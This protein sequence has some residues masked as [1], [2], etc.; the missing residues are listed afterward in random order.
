MSE[1]STNDNC[2]LCEVS[3]KIQFGNLRTPSHSSSENLFKPSKR[4][5][6]FGVVLS[7]IC[8]QVGLPLT[9]DSAKYSD[10]VCNP[11]GRKIR[12]LG[13]L[14]QFVKKAATA[15]TSTPVKTSKRTLDTPEKA[16]PPWRKSKS[17]RI[18][19]PVG[20][21]HF[22]DVSPAKSRKSL[23][24]AGEN[25]ENTSSLSLERENEMLSK[26]NVENLPSDGV[27][28]LYLNQSGNVT[29]RIPRDSQTKT[30][31][32]NIAAKKWREVSN[33]ILKHVEIMPELSKGICKLV[34]KEFDEYIKSECMLE[35]RNPDELAGFSNKLFMEE[36]RVFCPVWFNCAL[37][38]SGVSEDAVK[39]CGPDVNSLALA[40]ATIARVRNAKASAAH[41]RI[42]TILF[43]SGV[44]HDDLKRL[45]RLGVCMSPDSIVIMQKKM[46]EQLEGK[47][48][49]WK[50]TIV[51]NRCAL[52]LAREIL[53]KQIAT[54]LDLSEESLRS[55]E[56][57]STKGTKH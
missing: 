21:T 55:Y 19:S 20:K 33:G 34:S 14:Y 35:A 1:K 30:L 23:A 50:D 46:N 15:T 31:V 57:Y 24:F 53:Q 54:P 52:V 16:S 12:N 32:K 40:T 27:K 17:V 3:F 49:V 44:K 41:Y 4:K 28:I 7:E 56:F 36:V 18:N 38:A 37:G 42:S 2:R 10:R 29:V 22:R 51:E 45:N 5:D 8:R 25:I 43:H 26:L 13:Q 47:L 48:Q 6:C 11:C 9:Q 39:V